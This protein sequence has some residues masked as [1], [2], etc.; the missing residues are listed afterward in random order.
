MSSC[1]LGSHEGNEKRL[2]YSLDIGAGKGQGSEL[3]VALKLPESTHFQLTMVEVKQKIKGA[4]TVI[5]KTKQ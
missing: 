2:I 3:R 1:R 5:D 4:V